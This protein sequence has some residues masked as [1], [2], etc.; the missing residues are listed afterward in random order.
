MRKGRTL[1]TDDSTSSPEGVEHLEDLAAER[2][3]VPLPSVGCKPVSQPNA[4]R[5]PVPRPCARGRNR[6]AALRGM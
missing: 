3:T 5:K 1:L 4:G 2:D 6:T